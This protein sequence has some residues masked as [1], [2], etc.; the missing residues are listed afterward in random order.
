MKRYEHRLHSA[1]AAFVAAFCAGATAFAATES[2]QVAGT[3][4]FVA[5]GLALTIGG[6]G[7]ARAFT[8]WWEL[9]K[10]WKI[11]RFVGVPLAAIGVFLLVFAAVESPPVRGEGLPWLFKYDEGVARAKETSRPMMVDF[12]A[13]WCGACQEMEA[14]IFHHQDVRSRLA[15]DFV[16][17]KVD[18]DNKYEP[19]QKAFAQQGFSGLP[20]VAFISPSGETLEQSTFE[21]K[22]SLDE[23]QSRLDAVENGG[24]VQ[25][26][27]GEFQR[28]LEEQGLLAA[29]LLVFIAG[30]LA[31]LTPC[32]YPLIPI[33]VGI[34]GAK[35][36]D[37]RLHA[38]GLS[39]V[40]VLGIAVTY[41]V[42]GVAAASLGTVFG[43]AMQ[44]PWVLAAISLLFLVLGLSSLGVF[45]IRLPGAVQTKLSQTGGA[46]WAGAFVMGLVAGIIAAPCVGPIVAGILL[47]VAQQQDPMLGFG[48]LFTFAIGM[49][50][51]FLALGTFSSLLNRLP[52]SG[53]W[54]EGVKLIFGVVFI[55]MALY[56]LQF[57]FPQFAEAAKALWL[58]VG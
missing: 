23:F 24:E 20:A 5:L 56:Y 11:A 6:L 22:V 2:F 34:F 50:Q 35:Q 15:T 45:E 46:G 48:L 31:S 33:T 19:N 40:Y 49:G 12:T 28:T 44:N 52:Q 17:V 29:L 39:V 38:F 10:P 57:L 4:G 54:M 14:E 18:L 3:I 32:V 9:E 41:S 16:L 1:T 43:G 47:Y 7:L 8:G 36:A 21:G 42:L 37:T 13:D 51:L 26:S 55:A 53:G 58:L 25:D 27:R 30:I